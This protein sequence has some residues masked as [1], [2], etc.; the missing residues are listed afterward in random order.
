MSKCLA[1]VWNLWLEPA[2]ER[3][4]TV[5]EIEKLCTKNVFTGGTN[6]E[7]QTPKCRP[8]GAKNGTI[9]LPGILQGQGYGDAISKE[10]PWVSGLHDALWYQREEYQYAQEEGCQVP[11]LA[12][13]PRHYVGRAWYEREIE[14][15]ED[16][17]EEIFLFIEMTKWQSS[18]WL[19]GVYKGGDCSLCAPHEIGL[20]KIK[21]GSHTLTVC[22]DNRIQYPYRPDGHGFSDAL[23]TTWNGMAGEILLL[24]ETEL[25]ERQKQKQKYAKAHPRYVEV[26]EGKF[27][28]DGH[29]E[30]FR[31]THFGG[32]YPL[33]GYPTSDPSWWEKLMATVKEWG[34]NFIRC[35]SYCPP[36]AAFVAADKAGVYLQVECGMWNV[37]QDGIEMLSVLR[38]ETEK[39]LRTFGHHPS[40]VLF[41]PTNEP[42]GDWYA[43]LKRW[44]KETRAF[45]KELGYENR[46]VYTAQS[47]WFYDKAPKD[48]MQ[49]ETEYLYF[50]RSAYGPFLGGNIRN[51]EGWKGKDYL[52]SLEGAKLPV[53]CHEMG[54]WCA[55]PDFSVEQKFSG[56]LQPGN[57]RV[58]RENA[59]AHGVLWR[60]KEFVYCSGK[61]QVM[62]Y[63]EDLEANFRTPHMYG[64]EMLDLHDYLGQGTALV[65]ILDPFWES[66]GYVTPEEFREFCQETVLLARVPSYVYKN[67]DHVT[68]PVE[69]C[70]FG[71]E[72]LKDREIIWKLLD[73]E[74]VLGSGTWFLGEIPVG[75]NIKIGDIML[76]FSK[77]RTHKKL[78]LSV[79]MAPAGCLHEAEKDTANHWDLYVFAKE[80]LHQIQTPASVIYTREWSKAKAALKDGKNVVF[81]PYLSALDYDC[82][83]VTMRPVFWNA[84]MGPGWQRNVGIAVEKEHPALAGF[85]T[86]EYGGWLWEDILEQ[87]RG[88]RTDFMKEG[89]KPIVTVIDEWNRNFPLALAMEAK[90]ENGNLLLVSACLE[91]TFEERPAASSL[92]DALLSYAASDRFCPSVEICADDVEKQLFSVKNVENS[93]IKYEY[94]ALNVPFCA[95][96]LEKLSVSPKLSG[97][98]KLSMSEKLSVMDKNALLDANPNRSVRVEAETYPIVIT[99]YLPKRQC[100]EGIFYLQ[101]QKDR[102]HEG[103]IKDCLIQIRQQENPDVWNT[104]WSGE[105]KNG[106]SLQKVMF[107][108]EYET[109]AVRVA[110]FSGYGVQRK[111][112]WNGEPW[113]WYPE[114]QKEKAIVQAAALSVICKG[115][116]VEDDEVFWGRRKRSTT[117][118]IED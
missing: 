29:M 21:A 5:S 36:E 51:F 82:P 75:K 3:A 81:S 55:Y 44:V 16:S 118:E 72:A 30:Y 47:G 11:F 116:I 12:Q 4:E 88:F 70:H 1:G 109:D 20:G 65:G 85:P 94:C 104:V 43:P 80:A 83:A 25:Q 23:G 26:K 61:N 114:Y 98:E 95:P 58:F 35:H 39:I 90:V 74:R 84:Q 41:S 111:P 64:F 33:T 101:D 8:E 45:D 79:C 53:I 42:G 15:V 27:F 102:M 96:E 54:Q 66:K 110:V 40:F 112:S 69:V 103:G 22:I 77:I 50:H 73:G 13:P 71:R 91:G 7:C 86:E 106:F 57:Y 87:A 60:N 52:P 48:V 46:R 38:R 68:V 63:K 108:V 28:V 2:A 67:T 9:V 93:G 62:M 117:K 17:E 115:V 32:E 56:Y 107:D 10:T 100:V 19:D 113:G 105:L 97:L 99:M 24:S 89:W 37:F 76:D 78:V 34:L 31:G 6:E 92:K 14:M 49:D 59:R 18:V